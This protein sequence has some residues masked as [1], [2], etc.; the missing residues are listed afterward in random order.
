MSADLQGE[1][2]A[3]TEH[4]INLAINVFQ[5]VG[6]KRWIDQIEILKSEHIYIDI[7]KIIFPETII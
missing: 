4:I 7:C 2:D 3:A 5:N 1:E 6:I